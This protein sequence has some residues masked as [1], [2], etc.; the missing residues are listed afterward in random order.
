MRWERVRG[1]L[2]ERM[3]LQPDESGRFLWAEYSLGLTA[4]LPNAEIMVAGPLVALFAAVATGAERGSGGRIWYLFASSNTE[5]PAP[6]G[7]RIAP[8]R[9]RQ[10]PRHEHELV[11]D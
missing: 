11:T 4:L 5:D 2:G 7:R 8:S 1:I 10:P 6:I 3:K 9:E